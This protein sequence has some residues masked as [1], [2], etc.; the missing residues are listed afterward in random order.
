MQKFE[1]LQ[2]QVTS[3]GANLLVIMVEPQRGLGIFHR[4]Q[5]DMYCAIEA[6]MC[7]AMHANS[8]CPT[9]TLRL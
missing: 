2:Q 3:S 4:S 1:I 5:C 6:T 7:I 8:K 9:Q